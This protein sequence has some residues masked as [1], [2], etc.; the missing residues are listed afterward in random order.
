MTDQA[1]SVP[2]VCWRLVVDGQRVGAVD[3]T[4]CKTR[5]IKRL[6]TQSSGAGLNNVP[7]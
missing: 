2:P 3:K 5:D 7:L 6:L 4:V 1:V